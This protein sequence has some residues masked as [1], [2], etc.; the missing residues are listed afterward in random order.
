MKIVT[1]FIIG[2][3]V[4]IFA[5]SIL[6]S[7]RVQSEILSLVF[8]DV[9]QG[10]ATLISKGN[11]QILVD[12]GPDSSVLKCLDTFMPKFDRQI[13]LIVATHPDADHIGGLK[14]VYDRYSVSSTLTRYVGKDNQT[15]LSFRE[16]LLEEKKHGMRVFSVFNLPKFVFYGVSVKAWGM[17]E[18]LESEQLFNDVPEVAL[19]DILNQQVSIKSD[20]NDLSIALFIEYENFTAILPGDLEKTSESALVSSNLLGKTTTL[21]AG[22][23]GA[24]T[25]SST[26]F[27]TQLQ[28]EQIV[29][30]SGQ[31][32]TYGHPDDEVLQRLQQFSPH[33]WR[34]DS[35]GAV[36]VRSDG[37]RYWIETENGIDFSFQ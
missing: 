10:D 9:G 6:I 7:L 33:I 23:H 13:E 21:K 11:T 8:C 25:S 5:Y 4:V 3:T 31:D 27:L 26:D 32:N 16:G 12:G 34:T 19:S 35:M 22:H 30:S 24:N 20:Y 36:E 29:I 2:V 18:P 14:A 1:Y 17:E 37:M 15:F 28:P